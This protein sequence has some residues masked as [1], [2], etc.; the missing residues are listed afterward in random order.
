MP[1]LQKTEVT[2]VIYFEGTGAMTATIKATAVADNGD[3]T[4]R[5][6][7]TAVHGFVATR[8]VPIQMEIEGTDNYDGVRQ[9]VN[10]SATDM[11]D[12]IA[13]F[14][15]ETPAGTETIK[16]NIKPNRP[17]Q[18]KNFEMSLNTAPTTAEDLTI[19]LDS[20]RGTNY[21]HNIRT[22]PILGLTDKDWRIERDERKSRLREDR[23]RFAYANA[24][25]RTITMTVEYEIVS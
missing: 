9:V 14:V 13:S 24:D 23:I 1:V 11:F 22:I 4:V 3:G 17:F 19:D 15:A 7:T 21:D 6:Q 10:I 18:L 5:F 25:G 16:F 20:S 8:A 12:I 2:D